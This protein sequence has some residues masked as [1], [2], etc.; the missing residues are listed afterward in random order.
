MRAEDLQRLEQKF[1]ANDLRRPEEQFRDALELGVP[2]ARIL[3]QE[4]HADLSPE[5]FGI[6]WWREH[7]PTRRRILIGDQLGLSAIAI[8]TNLVEARL[9]HLE[10]LDLLERCGRRSGLHVAVTPQGQLHTE[11]RRLESAADHLPGEQATLNIVGFFRAVGSALDCLGASMVGVAA[12]PTRLLRAGMREAREGLEGANGG[13][14]G[15]VAQLELHE[16]FEAL[17]QAAGPTGWLEWVGNFRNMVVH[18]GR[19]LNMWMCLPTGGRVALPDGRIQVGLEEVLYLTRD[20]SRG[21]IDCWRDDVEHFTLA[22]D[23]RETINGI[24]AS[25]KFLVERTSALL[26]ALWRRRRAHPDLLVQPDRQWPDVNL[27]APP[28]FRGYRPRPPT[29]G[30]TSMVSSPAFTQRLQAA[31]LQGDRRARWA[32]FD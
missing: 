5:H 29:A 2:S 16:Q 6:A 13:S 22:E 9:H 14:D 32:G 17:V 10:A 3:A 15:A 12:L 26:L 21:E 7:V 18:R 4:I 25:T 27:P 23:A 11:L 8:E 19:H 31:G 30:D 1:P 24:W 20:P 28:T